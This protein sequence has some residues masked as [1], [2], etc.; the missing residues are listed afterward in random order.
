MKVT[1]EELS[2]S[3]RALNVEVAPEQVAAT[4]EATLK[5]LSR[6]IHVPG[7]RKG[8]VP[9]EILQ[10]RF[11]SDIQEEVLRE[12][13]PDSYRQALTQVELTPVSQPR[14]E[15]VHFHAGEPLRY[16]AIVE[17]KPPVTMKDYRGI[18]L[19]RK[20]VEVT[21]Q[22]VDRALEFL[23]EDAAEYAPM[24]GWPAMRDDLIVL[25]HEGSIHGKPFKGG[26]GKNLTL[27]LGRGG[28]LP[29]FEEQ[30]VG[31]QKGDSK[32]FR[33][34]FPADFPRKDLAGRTAEFRV[35][36]KEVKKRRVPELNDE[37]ARTAGDVES[38]AALRDKLRERLKARKVREQEVELKRTL[39]EKLGAT[40]EVE[41]PEALVEAEA[42]SLLQ[43]ML[44]TLRA[45]G[46]RVQG[47]AENAEALSARAF[48]MARRRVK[49]S[50]LL[51]AVARQENLTVSDAEVE[52]E[53]EAMAAAYPA[54][55]GT[56][57]GVPVRRAME[58]P[59]RR[60]GLQGRLLERKALEFL[61]Q[62]ARITEG[63]NLITPA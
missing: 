26:S 35:T 4:M 7:F 40:H 20:A 28:Y 9:P 42:A 15:D 10:R 30:V 34:T 47:L 60:A 19:E 57:G 18:P 1:V 8:K 17:V 27:L 48:E 51:D 6:K 53:I 45:S 13:I 12:L 36:I 41:L 5:E 46:G 29:G 2:P 62:E 52:A 33:L 22:E 23:R 21:D 3:R 11:Q 14:V 16:R 39:L 54:M 56:E 24:E 38:V 63:Y 37:F 49:E 44:G 50:L 59:G 32:Q 43:E 25:D 61:Y 31:L 55:G 58:D